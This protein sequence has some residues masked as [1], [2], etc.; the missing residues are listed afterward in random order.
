M[1]GLSD[2]ALAICNEHYDAIHDTTKGCKE[3]PL[4]KECLC[5]RGGDSGLAD[6][7]K[8]LNEAAE[9]VSK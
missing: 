9:K 1:I 4:S 6:W 5:I 7:R 2:K 8:R 3:C